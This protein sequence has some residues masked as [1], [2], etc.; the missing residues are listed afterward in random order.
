MIHDIDQFSRSAVEYG[1]P[2]SS[3]IRTDHRRST[4]HTLDWGHTEVLIDRERDARDSSLDQDYQ[5]IITWRLQCENIGL[6]F[7]LL[8]NLSL[9]W[10]IPSIGE[11]EILFWHFEK[12]IHNQSDTLRERESREREKIG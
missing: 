1:L 5:F 9:E 4:C 12:C 8:E 2:E 7:N 11:D 6:S 3:L 10:V